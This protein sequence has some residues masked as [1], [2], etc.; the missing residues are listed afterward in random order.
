VTRWHV[1]CDACDSASWIGAA[2]GAFAAWCEACQQGVALAAS[3]ASHDGATCPRCGRMLTLSAPRF[4]EIYGELQN[5]AAV[6]A[7]WDGD[8]E[9][10]AE[11]LPDRPRFL[12]DLTPDAPASSDEPEVR[13]A[14]LALT[15]GAYAE[16]R[17]QLEALERSRADARLSRALA[18]ALERTGDLAGAEAA[19]DRALAADDT[20]RMRLQRGALRARRADFAAAREDLA[21]AGDDFEARWDRAALGLLEAVSVTPGLP[22]RES[23]DAARREA[24]EPS[25]Y[26]SDHT[27]GRLLWSLLAGR[28]RSRSVMELS[29]CPDAR[30][31]RAAEVELEFDTFWDR[32]MVLEGYARLALAEDAARVAAPLALALIRQLAAE[33]SLASDSAG[34]IATVFDAAVHAISRGRPGGACDAILGLLKRADLQHYRVPCRHCGR[35][36][37][38]VDQ[39]EEHEDDAGREVPHELH[40]APDDHRP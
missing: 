23:I 33:P 1:A 30:T 22:A 8:P 15:A 14:L 32:A 4:V 25:S 5:L 21:R 38:G 29:P 37:I 19:L 40:S 12:T 24:G 16:A 3:T 20:P 35:G 27:I 9:P 7:A 36:S 26:W 10:L 28:A 17:T 13:D 6:L 11:L 2:G 31:L 34:S 39:I 18:I